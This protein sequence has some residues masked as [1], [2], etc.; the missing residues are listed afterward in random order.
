MFSASKSNIILAYRFRE[1]SCETDERHYFPSHYSKNIADLTSINVI[2]VWRH[3][4][5]LTTVHR[6]TN[7]PYKLWTIKIKTLSSDIYYIIFAIT[8]IV[9]YEML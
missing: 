5:V 3:S 2:S 7:V 8:N 1:I 4:Y 9:Y 6:M